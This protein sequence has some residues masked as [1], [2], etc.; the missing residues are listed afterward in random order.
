MSLL[1]ELA[2]GG[3]GVVYKARQVSLN[4]VVALKMILRGQLASA[5]D[6]RRF[7]QEAEAAAIL[8]HPHI[9]PIYEVGEHQ[10]QQYFSMKLIEGNNLADRLL[11]RP[12]DDLRSIVE[13]LVKVTRAVHYAHQRGILHRD[14]KPANVLLDRDGTP[15]VTDF[16]LAKKVEGDSSITQSG[17][18]VGTPAY[19]APEQARAEKQLSTAADVYSLGAIL[20]EALAGRPPFKSGTVAETIMAVIHQ[21]AADPRTVN[22]A[23]ERD[24]SVVALK[25]LEKDPARRYESAAALADELERWLAGEPITARP[26]SRLERARKWARRHPV[27]VGLLAAIVLALVAGT[28]STIYWAVTADKRAY[29]AQVSADD[30]VTQFNEATTQKIRAEEALVREKDTAHKLAVALEE[31]RDNRRT[32]YVSD[33]ARS[34][35]EWMTNNAALASRLLDASPADLRGWEWHHLQRVRHAYVREFSG[36]PGASTFG[37]FSPDGTKLLTVGQTGIKVWDVG[38]GKAVRTFRGH[39]HTPTSAA[40]FPD[41]KR[42]ISA[43]NELWRIGDRKGGDVHIWETETG[44][45]LHTFGTEHG[46]VEAVAVDPDGKAV[47]TVGLDDKLRVWVADTAKMLFARDLPKAEKSSGT[48]RGVAFRPNS[49]HLAASSK[50]GLVL[51]DTTTQEE[52]RRLADEVLPQYSRDGKQLITVKDSTTVTVTDA[53]SGKAGFSYRIPSTAI[54]SV[55]LRGDGTRLAVGGFDGLV[56]VIDLVGKTELY[57]IRGQQGQAMGVAYSPDGKWLV[58]SHGDPIFELLGSLV[59]RKALPAVIRLWDAERAQDYRTVPYSTGGFAAHP[60]EPLAFVAA[61][62]EVHVYDLRTGAR[63]RTLKAAPEPVSH[64]ALSPDGTALAVAWEVPG[65]RL[66]QLFPGAY[67]IK[68]DSH[69]SRLQILDTVTGAVKLPEVKADKQCHDLAFSPDG[70]M[71]AVARAAGRT[72]LVEVATGNSL[73]TLSGLDSGSSTVR[74]TPDGRTLIRSATGQMH[75]DNQEPARL[76][77]G[78]IE[79]WDVATQRKDRA[80]DTGDEKCHAVALSPDGRTLAAAVGEDVWLIDLSDLA[81]EHERIGAE[82]YALAFADNGK[83]LITYTVYGVKMW[84][85]RGRR[86][87]LTLGGNWAS[88]QGNTGRVA[89]SPSGYLLASDPE[90]LRVYDGR[91]FSTPAPA[92]VAA[93]KRLGSGPKPGPKTDA[94]PDDR[95]DTVRLA[96]KQSIEAMKD[97]QGAALLHAMAALTADTDFGRRATHRLRV[98]LALQRH[99]KLRPVVAPGATDPSAFAADAVA[100]PPGTANVSD[101]TEAWHA[102][103]STLISADG[104]RLASYNRVTTEARLKEAKVGGR[105]PWWVRVFDART[106]RPV[107]P[108]IDVGQR[109]SDGRIELSPDGKKVAA[110]LHQPVTAK[111]VGEDEPSGPAVVRM[112]NVETGHR[113]GEDV[114][115]PFKHEKKAWLW[116]VAE[117][118]ILV[119]TGEEDRSKTPAWDAETM[120][121]LDLPGPFDR[122][123]GW[124]YSPH[125]VTGKQD[126]PAFVWDGRIMKPVGKPLERSG[127]ANAVVSRDGSV[128]VLAYSYWVEAWDTKT[129]EVRHPRVL[130]RGGAKALAVSQTGSQ[131]AAAY[132]GEEFKHLAR[133][134]NARTGD[135]ISPPIELPDTPRDVRFVAGG[136]ALLTVTER[137]ARLWDARTGEPLTLPWTGDDP[138][139][140]GFASPI[141][142]ALAGDTLLCQRTPQTS[143]FDEWRLVDGWRLP[144]PGDRTAEEL[145]VLAEALAGRRRTAD[146]RLTSIPADEL[147][148]LRRMAVARFPTAF[149]TPIGRPED[150]VTRRPDPRTTQLIAIL[151][152]AKQPVERRVSACERLGELKAVEAQGPLTTAL[153]ADGDARARAAAARALGALSPL[154]PESVAALRRS[155]REEGNTSVRAGAARALRGPAAKQ[156]S[157]DLVRALK[158]DKAPEVR[159]GR[160]LL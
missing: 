3:M 67:E 64:L 74:F 148:V 86:D 149:G 93:K 77:P 84:D 20:Y 36:V 48:F 136:S 53:D 94:A 156:V 100:D 124:D 68:H 155:L 24:L 78:T 25:C 14:L 66:K 132:R 28:A 123:F 73:A 37:G 133:V 113:V 96:V 95:P 118:R 58:S 51:L 104:R 135:A 46:G 9:L 106:G 70:S 160:R 26:V 152:D 33:L 23:A 19:M 108:V 131:F 29:Q 153:R 65:K 142:F 87:L 12:V 101:P 15:Y 89:F 5:A 35:N 151:T 72:D 102:A 16:G 144:S 159:A 62:T 71:L 125:F 47:A 85:V 57:T 27:E 139:G 56:R 32:M 8:D 4:R 103:S 121:P 22:A 38:S 105:S 34:A 81:A 109:V 11:D 52:I 98:E 55:G 83:R 60:K 40:F 116:F 110:I 147:M 13:L 6:V 31:A 157:G 79:F 45:V 39:T 61:G 141:R 158:E 128:A 92:A 10:G 80:I 137:E 41:G 49:S 130:I 114:S 43:S 91:E 146:G 54:L 88:A 30:A 140:F 59:G 90:G 134:W 120:K 154:P 2:R 69:P 21:E 75:I 50:G 18:V 44:R 117:G 97:D 129:G 122:V 119:A 112:W 1:A 126:G 143:Q 127:L 42:V 115:V 17:A 82:A 107:G 7:R 111:K 63:V 150:V 145:K 76:N 138:I 99:A